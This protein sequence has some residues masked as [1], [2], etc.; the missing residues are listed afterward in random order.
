MCEIPVPLCVD[1][2]AYTVGLQL[3]NWEHQRRQELGL[4]ALNS[5]GLLHALWELPYGIPFPITAFKMIDRETLSESNSG[6]VTRRHDSFLREYQP[7]GVIRSVVVSD[8]SLDR[9]VTK[10]AE[11]PAIFRRVATWQTAAPIRLTAV[12]DLALTRAKTLGVGVEVDDGI[13][14][15]ELVP[16]ARA[17]RGNPAVF[18]WWLAELAYRNLIASKEPTV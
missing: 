9:A 18:R 8:Q 12:S 11:H 15:Y 7:P 10:V 13:R 1:R 17:M 3:D 6:W 14:K 5:T 16:P 4:G 2:R